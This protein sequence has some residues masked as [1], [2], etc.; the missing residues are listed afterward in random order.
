MEFKEK[1]DDTA[2]LPAEIIREARTPINDGPVNRLYRLFGSRG[3]AKL[4]SQF[5]DNTDENSGYFNLNQLI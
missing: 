1:L 3:M 4:L 5:T 2:F